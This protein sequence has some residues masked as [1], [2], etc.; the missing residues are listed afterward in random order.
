MITL[1]VM[2]TTC[3]GTQA[4]GYEQARREALFLTDKMAYELNLTDAQYDAAYEI[5][6]DYLLGVTD[7]SNVFG[8]Y[9]ERRNLDFSYILLD[10]Q[11]TAFCAARYFYRPL[12]WDAGHWHFGIY[13]RYPVRTYFYFGHPTVY[14]SYRGGHSWHSNG[15]RS[16]WQGQRQTFNHGGQH[17]G[18]RDNRRNVGGG[19]HN[20]N[21][22]PSTGMNHGGNRNHGNNHNGVGNPNGGNHNGVG[23]HNGGNRNGIGTP[24][25][26]NRHNMGRPN[27]STRVT[28]NGEN[29]N[30]AGAG[31]STPS[32]SIPNTSAPSTSGSRFGGARS[33]QRSTPSFSNS[34][35]RSN[36]GSSF[37]GT[38]NGS[39][40]SSSRSTSSFSNSSSSSNRSTSGSHSGGGRSG[41]GSRNGGFG[42][43]RR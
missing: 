35:S 38:R 12:Y 33:T 37:S 18:M 4:M 26:N 2:L 17:V 8:V 9:W 41:G 7:R 43:G 10:W 6:L 25:G 42:G 20:G 1:I 5:N 39:S 16:F 24:N 22:R 28:V 40:S 21:S 3:I 34:G 13:T 27:S 36:S 15:G 23:N 19:V 30:G 11:Y 29:R 32:T 14:A 31:A